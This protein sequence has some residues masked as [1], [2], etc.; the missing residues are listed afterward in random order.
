MID[1]R[2]SEK[3]RA[4]EFRVHRGRVKEKAKR[5]AGRNYGLQCSE[6]QDLQ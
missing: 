4:V 6:L 3:L 5:N 2:I 1:G